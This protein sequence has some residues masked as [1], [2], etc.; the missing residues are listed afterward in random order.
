MTCHRTIC[1]I[2]VFIM[3]VALV[4]IEMRVLHSCRSTAECTTLATVKSQADMFS[5]FTDLLVNLFTTSPKKCSV[6][7][8]FSHYVT[9]KSANFLFIN[10]S[11]GCTTN[12]ITFYAFISFKLKD[13]LKPLETVYKCI[14]FFKM[15]FC[16]FTFIFR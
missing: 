2:I 8:P 16:S 9:K 3:V 13:T 15:E 1:L 12:K 14:L 5:A 11:I 4:T 6:K 7:T 10:W